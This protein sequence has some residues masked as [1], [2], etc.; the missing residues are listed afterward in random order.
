MIQFTQREGTTGGTT[1]GRGYRNLQRKDSQGT[2]RG[3][4]MQNREIESENIYMIILRKF[5][6]MRYKMIDI[7]AE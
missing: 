4:R 5:C 7:T 2:E 1:E 3:S 6:K